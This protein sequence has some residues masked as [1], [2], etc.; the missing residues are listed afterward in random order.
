VPEGLCKCCTEVDLTQ[1]SCSHV[2]LDS[3]IRQLDANMDA[4]TRG[5]V[6]DACS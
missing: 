1:G 6:D 5:S 2:T 4:G 3:L